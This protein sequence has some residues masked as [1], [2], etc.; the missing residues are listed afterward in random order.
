MLLVQRVET[1]CTHYNV[2]KLDELGPLKGLSKIVN[3]H[4]LFR[5]ID[6]MYFFS[7]D[8]VLNEIVSYVYV[9]G[10]FTREEDTILF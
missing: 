5:A 9:L 2:S 3:N 1:F 7:I 10:P 4:F 8:V 6:Y